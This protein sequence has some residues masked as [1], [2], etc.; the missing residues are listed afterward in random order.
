MVEL[1]NGTLLVNVRNEMHYHCK[2]RV[3][4]TSYDGGD[5]F[6]I[7]NMRT[8]STLVDPPCQGSTFIHSDGTMYFS[9]PASGSQRVNMTLRWSQDFGRTWDGFLTV[10][11]KQA[12]YSCLTQIDENHMGLLY[13]R[14]GYG[15][16]AFARI[17][18][19]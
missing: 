2:C 10:Y 1:P 12:E 13:E 16:I 15:D 7:R 18:L 11:A 9:N 5:T 19:N 4:L 14:D 8:D 3:W 17:K 6:P